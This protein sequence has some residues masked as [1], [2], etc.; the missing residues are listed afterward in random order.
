MID[1]EFSEYIKSCFKTAIIVDRVMPG[2]KYLD[3]PVIDPED[4]AVVTKE[5]IKIY[6]MVC[7]DWVHAFNPDNIFTFGLLW[8]YY[9]RLPIKILQKEYS[10]SKQTIFNYRNQ[11]IDLIYDYVR[12]MDARRD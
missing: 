5:D 9:K 6:E 2:I 10:C 4:R 11:G 8:K 7:F 3:K 1:K 12:K